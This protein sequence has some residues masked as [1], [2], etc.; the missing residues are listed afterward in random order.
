MT[1]FDSQSI[2]ISNEWVNQEYKHLIVKVDK[3]AANVKPGQFFNLLCP[4]TQQDKPYFRRPMSTYFADRQTGQ[5]EF[6]YKVVGSGT[7]TLAMLKANDTLP[8]L[9]P[10]GNG[11]NLKA[12][13]RHILIVGRGVGLATLAPLAEAAATQHIHVT[14]ILSAR[15]HANLMSQARFHKINA[16]VIEVVDNDNSSH[17]SNVESLIHSI[18]Q[19]SPLD[20]VFTCGSTRLTQLLQRITSQLHLEGQVALEQHMACGIGMC[21]CCVKPFHID[22]EDIPRSKRVCIDGPIF[23][24]KEFIA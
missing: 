1:I 21:Y 15:N 18:H 13:Y 3:D 12:T 10:L 7:R 24:L 16:N 23:D 14:A 5:V 2:V 9:G 6:L 17:I 20:A 8:I 11:F 22:G 19:K 4:Q